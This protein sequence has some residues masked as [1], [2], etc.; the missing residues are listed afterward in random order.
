MLEVRCSVKAIKHYER[1]AFDRET[2]RKIV[3]EFRAVNPRMVFNQMTLSHASEVWTYDS[4]EEFLAEI[5]DKNTIELNLRVPG[6][7]DNLWLNTF[8]SAADGFNFSSSISIT[9]P[10]RET[11]LRIRNLATAEGDRLFIPVPP[12]PVKPVEA[13][14]PVKPKV[15]IGHGHSAAWRD[16]KDHLQDKHQIEAIA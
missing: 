13:I 15:F 5:S 3:A 16:L 7:D 11:I 8:G 4:F 6:E 2:I 1:V 9:S 10:N 12:K 14:A